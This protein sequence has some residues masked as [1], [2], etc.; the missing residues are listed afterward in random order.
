MRHLVL[1]FEPRLCDPLS[2]RR[3]L[4]YHGQHCPVLPGGG[5]RSSLVGRN[6]SLRWP[7]QWRLVGVVGVFEH[8][9]SRHADSPVQLPDARHR[10]WR[11]AVPRCFVSVVW[12]R[13]ARGGW[14]LERLV[15]V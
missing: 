14:R 13:A 9:G 10:Q 6:D 2:F 1:D 12:H 4:V 15:G 8:D 3:H 5:F 11:H 7:L